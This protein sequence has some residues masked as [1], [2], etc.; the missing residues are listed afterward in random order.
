MACVNVRTCRPRPPL[1]GYLI[2]VPSTELE[3]SGDLQRPE[4]ATLRKPQ[5]LKACPHECT[6]SLSRGMSLERQG[7]RL[8]PCKMIGGTP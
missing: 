4:L 2:F 3:E 5:H 6:T 8:R 7:S 1:W